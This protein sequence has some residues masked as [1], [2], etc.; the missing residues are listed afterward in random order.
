MTRTKQIPSLA[1]LALVLPAL[2]FSSCATAREA[3]PSGFLGNYSNMKEG[4]YFKQEAVEPGADFKKF[5]AVK[6]APVNLSYLD[7]RTGCDTGELENLGSEFRKNVEDQ[8]REQGFTITASPGE[9]TLILSL[10][11]TNIEP[12][13]ALVNAGLTAA[14]IVTPFPTSIF[15]K[16]GKTSF[17]GK[18]I[19]GATGKELAQFAEERTGAGGKMNLKTLTVGK[20]KKFTN[21]Q[22]VFSGWSKNLG[23][24]LKDLTTSPP[25]GI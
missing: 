15:D 2:L 25:A 22:A 3:T 12:P 24:M 5:K 1:Y 13:D 17:E 10:A 16:D 9:N 11:L 7:T 14:S 18:L 6:V 8:L 20:Y 21:T 19:D 4:T 23:S